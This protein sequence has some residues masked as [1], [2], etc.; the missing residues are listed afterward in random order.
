[1]KTM[2]GHTEFVSA[3]ILICWL[4]VWEMCLLWGKRW[5]SVEG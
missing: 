3:A 4:L 1:M 5:C 2:E